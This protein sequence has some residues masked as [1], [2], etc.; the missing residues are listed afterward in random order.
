MPFGF[1][2]IF[3]LASPACPPV[4]SFFCGRVPWLYQYWPGGFFMLFVVL[5]LGTPK[6]STGN[7][8]GF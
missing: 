7:D 3:I 5:C 4:V 8:S 6:G 2:K 1:S